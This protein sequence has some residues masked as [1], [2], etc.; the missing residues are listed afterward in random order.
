M[1]VLPED[2]F[3]GAMQIN[4]AAQMVITADVTAV[5]ARVSDQALDSQ[6][7]TTGVGGFALS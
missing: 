4:G 2:I 3:F 5:L 7:L 1:R 6:C